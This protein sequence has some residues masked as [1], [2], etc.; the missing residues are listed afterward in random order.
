MFGGGREFG[1]LRSVLTLQRTHLLTLL[2]LIQNRRGR[3]TSRLV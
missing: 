2:I 3:R 1:L